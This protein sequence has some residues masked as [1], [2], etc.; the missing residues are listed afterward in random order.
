MSTFCIVSL[1]CH[2]IFPTQPRLPKSD[3]SI[4]F[5][6]QIYSANIHEIQRSACHSLDYQSYLPENPFS[7][8]FKYRNRHV[9]LYLLPIFC[10]NNR[11]LCCISYW[12][13]YLS[14]GF[15]E[16]QILVQIMF[17]WCFCAVLT[18]FYLLTC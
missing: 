7:I 8:V 14:N 16:H 5:R 4:Y 1:K 12:C 10:D 3:V 13:T 18:L 9:R 11:V 17:K 15:A 2:K 6:C